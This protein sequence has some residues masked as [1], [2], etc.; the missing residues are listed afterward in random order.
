MYVTPPATTSS[1][2]RDGRRLSAHAV[3]IGTAFQRR[4][5]V[6]RLSVFVALAAGLCLPDLRRQRAGDPP[7]SVALR[8]VWSG[9]FGPGRNDFPRQQT[10]LGGLVSGDV[11]GGFPE[12][13]RQCARFAARAGFGQLQDRLGAAAQIAAGDGQTRTG[14]LERSGRSGRSLLGSGGIGSSGTPIDQQSLD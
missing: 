3:G 7:R 13:R 4:S 5:K 10:A 8:P 9:N 11:A 12:E 1:I 2:L 6:S 14:S